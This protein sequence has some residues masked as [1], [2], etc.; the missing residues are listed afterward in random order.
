MPDL[1]AGEYLLDALKE[2][3]PIRSNGMG[4]GAPD[5]QELVAFASANDLALQ[6]WE[7][8]LIRK[9]AAAY[10]SGFNSGEE[11]LSIPPMEREQ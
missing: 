4:L 2:L 6:P 8:R 3:G 7:F 9:M 11:P 1:E 10:L 5:W